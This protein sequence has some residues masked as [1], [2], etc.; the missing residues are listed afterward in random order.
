MAG[1]YLELLA[2]EWYEYQGYFVR[3]NVPVGPDDAPPEAELA[4]VAVHPG[5]ARMVHL[6]P[7]MDAHSW[8][9]REKRYGPKF[10]AGRRHLPRLM[11]RHRRSEL[12]QIALIGLGSRANHP[13]LGGARVL[14]LTDLLVGIL[15]AFKAGQGAGPVPRQ[16]P[17]LRTLQFVVDNRRAVAAALMDRDPRQ[18]SF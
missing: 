1:N 7:S 10:D 11:G 14:T 8:A 5:E 4:M 6:E 16:Y 12:E 3:R 13:E 9:A 2:A 18:M 15:E 17:I